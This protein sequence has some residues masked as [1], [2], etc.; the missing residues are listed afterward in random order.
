M[1]YTICLQICLNISDTMQGDY[2]GYSW[3]NLESTKG[4]D[5]RWV[6]EGISMKG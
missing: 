3:E 4:P 5:F 6:Y 2:E 1:Y